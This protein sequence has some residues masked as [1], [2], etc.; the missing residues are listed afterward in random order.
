MSVLYLM[1]FVCKY[2]KTHEG[3]FDSNLLNKAEA[4]LR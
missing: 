3:G 2:V 1:K 4:S